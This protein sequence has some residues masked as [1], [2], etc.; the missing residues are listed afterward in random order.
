M[1]AVMMEFNFRVCASPERL[2][3]FLEQ[4]EIAIDAACPFRVQR[5]RTVDEVNS[6]L[7]ARQ[8]DRL[9]VSGLFPPPQVWEIGYGFSDPTGRLTSDKLESISKDVTADLQGSRADN[10][11]ESAPWILTLATDTDRATRQTI[12]SRYRTLELARSSP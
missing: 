12:I 7:L 4:G 6:P 9:N 2:R 8:W 1:K 5:E 3:Q 10:F 11:S